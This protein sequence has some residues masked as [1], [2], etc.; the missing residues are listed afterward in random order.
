MKHIF[1]YIVINTKKKNKAERIKYIAKE[2]LDIETGDQ[3]RPPCEG[4]I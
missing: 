3:E 1:C 2:G 4:D